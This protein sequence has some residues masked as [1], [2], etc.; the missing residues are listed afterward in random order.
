VFFIY[1]G[2]G[3]FVGHFDEKDTELI[4]KAKALAADHGFEESQGNGFSGVDDFIARAVPPA[5][6]A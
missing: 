6:D 5:F 4:R 1:G 2:N 3:C